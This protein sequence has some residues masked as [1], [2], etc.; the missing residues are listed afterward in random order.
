M[1]SP[2]YCHSYAHAAV[3]NLAKG[4]NIS[5]GL[6]VRNI[7]LSTTTTTG[8]GIENSVRVARPQT[9]SAR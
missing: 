2:E 9:V 7:Y 4:V 6:K 1:R 8:E 5:R 3:R